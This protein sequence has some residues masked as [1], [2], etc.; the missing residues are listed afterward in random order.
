MLQQRTTPASNLAVKGTFKVSMPP[1]DELT[2]KQTDKLESDYGTGALNKRKRTFTAWPDDDY[3]PS[4][5]IE[6]SP[7]AAEKQRHSPLWRVLLHITGTANQVTTVGMDVWR[8]IVLGRADPSGNYRPD[9]DFAPYSAMRLG[10]SR[11]HALFK[12]GRS[13]LSLIDQHSTNGTWVNDK[14]LSPGRENPL[15]DGDKVELGDLR[16]TVRITNSP[17]GLLED[18]S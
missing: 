2:G 9:I 1:G 3:A 8:V 10:V 12:P 13:N 17:I 5:V 7:D 16:F 15:L 14:R 11:R 6:V 4:E 18:K